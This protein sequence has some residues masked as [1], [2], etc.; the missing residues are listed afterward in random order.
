MHAV[1]RPVTRPVT[2]RGLNRFLAGAAM[3][4]TAL[5]LTAACSSKSNTPA[6]GGGV[7]TTAPT[8]A[9]ST[10]AGSQAGTGPAMIQTAKTALG[11]FLA[12]RSGRT[13]YLFLAD[14]S[15]NSTCYDQCAQYWPPLLTSGAPTV[16]GGADDGKLGTTQRKDG[17]TQVTYNGHPLYYFL[18]DKAAGDTTGQGSS[19]FGAKW[20]VVSVDGNSITAMPGASSPGGGLNY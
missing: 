2:R 3:A 4:A 19:N 10:A 11:T 7:T 17:S 20:W 18:Q 16:G 13:L 1:T 6:A 15:T 9:N 14:T 12:D 5:V 8:A